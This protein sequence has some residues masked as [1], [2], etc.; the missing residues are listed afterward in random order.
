VAPYDRQYYQNNGQIGD[1]PALWFYARLIRRLIPNGPIL[2]FG[3]GTGFLMRRLSKFTRTDGFEI[4]AFAREDAQRMLPGSRFY[5][6][7][8][9]LPNKR[10]GGIVS[11]HVLEHI[12]D[13]KL[14]QIFECWKRVARPDARF[15]VVMPD[16]AGSGWALKKDKWIGFQDPTHV[17]L[18]SGSDW[19]QFLNGSGL[20]IDQSGSDGL[21][22]FPYGGTSKTI[23]A[24]HRGW[25]TVAQM[26]VGRLI[27]KP[28]EGESI[29][30]SGRF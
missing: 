5:S 29:I 15:L 25:K 17:N 18:K 26:A 30:L 27:I 14:A 10:Y 1:R 19:M 23:D 6:R 9:A 22:D 13:E 16:R 21:W 24:L 28:G 8:D 7:L 20:T 11:L 3:C 2:D 12:D 4:S